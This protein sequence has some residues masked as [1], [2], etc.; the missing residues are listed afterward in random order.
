VIDEKEDPKGDD[1]F[2]LKT[3][4]NNKD[5]KI[6]ETDRSFDKWT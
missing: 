6:S 4:A 3:F 1:N 2:I 5:M